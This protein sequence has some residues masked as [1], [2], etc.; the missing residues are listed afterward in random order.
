M[1]LLGEGAV[2]QQHGLA[3][4]SQAQD[5]LVREWPHGERG[6]PVWHT[7][8]PIDRLVRLTETW[9]RVCIGSTGEHWV[10]L[11]DPWRLRMDEAW[12]A[13]ARAHRRLPWIHMLRGMQLSKYEWPFAS[14]DSA[15]IGRN[16]YQPYNDARRMADRWNAANA[17]GRWIER[18]GPL[19]LFE[20]QAALDK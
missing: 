19:D 9:P 12:N 14:C 13:L 5:A 6:A 11:S 17:P 2:V 16:H 1:R 8:E 18:A 3:E 4:G 7:D 20:C 10:V 15:D